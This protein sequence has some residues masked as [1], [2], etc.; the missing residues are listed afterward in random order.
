[1]E[2]GFEAPKDTAWGHTRVLD[3]IPAEDHPDYDRALKSMTA[4]CGSLPA[5]VWVERNLEGELEVLGRCTRTF[6]AGP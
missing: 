4:W 2:P 6:R 3:E 1:M 5:E